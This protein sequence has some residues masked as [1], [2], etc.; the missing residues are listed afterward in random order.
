MTTTNKK[1]QKKIGKIIQV[2]M[3]ARVQDSTMAEHGIKKNDVIYVAGDS[4]FNVGE[5]DPYELR[6]LFVAA[7]VDKD[8]HILVDSGA[9][10]VDGLRLKPVSK[11]YQEKLTAVKFADF[12]EKEQP[13]P[14]AN[15]T[16]N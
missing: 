8:G 13:D 11:T 4:I 14:D 15:E 12:G 1:L 6:R 16:S 9:F 7:K 10:T 3:F 2:G 5:K